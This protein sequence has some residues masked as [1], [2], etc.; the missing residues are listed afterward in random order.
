MCSVLHA[1]S[2]V[3]CSLSIVQCYVYSVLCDVF[4]FQFSV[5]WIAKCSVFSV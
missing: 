1:V 4:S 2:S 3:Y 5:Q